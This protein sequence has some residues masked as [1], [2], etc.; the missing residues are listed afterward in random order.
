MLGVNGYGYYETIK[1]KGNVR[2]EKK[3]MT[4]NSGYELS[5][6]G[7]LQTQ[8]TLLMILR[9]SRWLLP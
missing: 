4:P 6:G 8:G 1:C 9:W 2:L 3:D 7:S 5:L